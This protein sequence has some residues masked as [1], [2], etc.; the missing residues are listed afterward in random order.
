MGTEQV[1]RRRAPLS[2]QVPGKERGRPQGTPDSLESLRGLGLDP[3]AP[4][5]IR[6]LIWK[7][8]PPRVTL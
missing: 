1:R 3:R 6:T 8:S 7:G 2:Q 5:R 4:C